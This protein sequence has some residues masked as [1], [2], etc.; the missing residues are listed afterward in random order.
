MTATD[1]DEGENGKVLYFLSQEARGAFTVDENTGC[2]TTAS[3]V[4]REKR[5]SYS[6]R[7]FAVDLSP[8]EPRNTSAQ[9]TAPDDNTSLIFQ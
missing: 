2:I 3:P 5:A 6:F 7:V 1:A 4:D 8:A 9:V